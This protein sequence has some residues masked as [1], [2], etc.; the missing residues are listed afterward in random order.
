MVYDVVQNK[1]DLAQ[2]LCKRCLAHNKSCS[3]A[4]E[5]LALS[6]EKE[7]EYKNAADCYEKV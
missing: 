7:M 6:M 1:Y 4:W 5:I 3:Q 2:D